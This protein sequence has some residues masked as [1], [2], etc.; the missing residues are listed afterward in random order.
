M[1]HQLVFLHYSERL[2]VIVATDCSSA[3]LEAAKIQR[4]NEKKV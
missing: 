1:L 4:P 3:I 2:L